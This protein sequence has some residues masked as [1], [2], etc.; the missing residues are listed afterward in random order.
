MHDIIMRHAWHN[1]LKPKEQK[2]EGEFWIKKNTNGWKDGN[3]EKTQIL[4]EKPTW[5]SSATTKQAIPLHNATWI[6]GFVTLFSWVVFK[7]TAIEAETKRN[8]M[9]NETSAINTPPA[10]NQ[11][12]QVPSKPST[13]PNPTQPTEVIPRELE[14]TAPASPKQSFLPYLNFG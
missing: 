13:N 11:E 10:P 7:N 8:R 5:F 6:W 2:G 9:A 4:Q 3:T 1:E 12:T 14:G